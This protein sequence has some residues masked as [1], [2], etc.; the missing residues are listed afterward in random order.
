MNPEDIAAAQEAAAIA[1][2][3]VKAAMQRVMESPVID[4][5]DFATLTGVHVST[6]QRA[7]AKNEGKDF[8]VPTGRIGQR[9][10]IP[11]APVREFLHLDNKVPA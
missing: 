9:W 3:R 5:H 7:L 6:V 11:S 2:E 8:P 10:V 4:L 1:A